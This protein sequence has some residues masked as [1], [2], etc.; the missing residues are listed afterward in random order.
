[1]LRLNTRRVLI[2]AGLTAF[3]TA[4]A[5]LC[6]SGFAPR[7]NGGARPQSWSGSP[8]PAAAQFAIGDFD[9][10]SQPDLASVQAGQSGYRDTRYSIDFRLSSGFRQTVDVTAPTGGLRLT[11][12][13]VNGDHFLDVIV[14]TLWTNRPV[15][16]L[17]NDGQGNFTRSDPFAFPEAFAAS[18]HCWSS[19]NDTIQDATAAVFS[20][21]LPGKREES[22]GTPVPQM[23]VVRLG[24][25]A[26]HFA[27]LS[28]GDSF[29]G[30]APPFLAVSR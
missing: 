13:D 4:L 6:L 12:W 21:Y 5:L 25:N 1:M 3:R 20:R 17:L 9:G 18:E 10:D 16:V 28:N 7:G 30:R 22:C 19:G 29:F 27:D 26:L 15:A 14:T 8:G 2:V 23:V 11:S 24:A